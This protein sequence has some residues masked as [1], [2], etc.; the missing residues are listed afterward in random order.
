MLGWTNWNEIFVCWNCSN[1]SLHLWRRW[2]WW[3]TM[4]EDLG[5]LVKRSAKILTLGF[6]SILKKAIIWNHS[7]TTRNT[8]SNELNYSGGK[9][10]AISLLRCLKNEHEKREELL[11]RTI[12]TSVMR[13]YFIMNGCD[14][15]PR[16]PNLVFKQKARPL[17]WHYVSKVM[18][19]MRSRFWKYCFDM[20]SSENIL[21]FVLI[22][23]NKSQGQTLNKV[24]LY[25]PK[26]DWSF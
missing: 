26:S 12:V 19:F 22:L 8:P 11:G 25:L 3:L 17:Q 1:L 15:K 20:S 5:S 16:D 9:K 2:A 18:L 10:D 13:I 4:E 7:Y 24:G 21:P 6:T 23:I 14:I